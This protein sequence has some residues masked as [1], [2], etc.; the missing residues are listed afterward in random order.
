MIDERI[1]WKTVED[2]L[3]TLHRRLQ[4]I[5][6]GPA[7]EMSPP[8]AQSVEGALLD[9]GAAIETAARMGESARPRVD[10]RA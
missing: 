1:Y 7:P 2:E 4:A 8:L 5:W 3:W 6:V 9:L 10:L